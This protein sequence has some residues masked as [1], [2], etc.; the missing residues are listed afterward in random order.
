MPRSGSSRAGVGRRNRRSR[1][2]GPMGFG[3]AVVLVLAVLAAVETFGPIGMPAR[4]W[5]NSAALWAGGISTIVSLAL[6]AR[7]GAPEQRRAW[8]LLCAAQITVLLS[9]VWY[10][11]ARPAGFNRL[12]QLGDAGF[13]AGGALAIAG[14]AAFPAEAKRGLELLR[15]VLDGIVVAGSVVLTVAVLALPTVLASGANPFTRL[16]TISLLAVDTVMATVAGLL[17]IRGDRA[18]R[19]VLGMLSIGFLCWAATDLT[20][21]V[22]NVRGLSTFGTA[23]PLGWAAGYAAIAIAARLPA[24]RRRPT[25]SRQDHDSPVADTII[26]FGILLVAAAANAPSM[27]A[28]LSPWMGVLWLVLVAA[29]VFRQLILIAD[30]E[31]LRRILERRVASRTREL[32]SVTQQSELLLNS[33]GD[34]IYGVDPQGVITFVNP[35]AARTLGYRAA[36]LIGQDAHRW[37]HAGRAEDVAADRGPCYIAEAIGGRT[38]TSAEDTYRCADG[39]RIPV[40]LT[41]SPLDGDD[42]THGAVIVFRDITQRREVDRMKREFVSVVSHELRTPLT[43]IRGSL[44]LLAGDRLGELSPPANRMITIALDS[45]ERLGR[46]VNDILDIERMESGSMPMDFRDHDA[47]ALVRTAVTQLRPMAADAGLQ[48]ATGTLDGRVTA[49]ADRIVQTLVNLIGNAIKFSPAGGVV[50]V[51]AVDD[52]RTGDDH[53]EMVQFRVADQGRGI[54]VDKLERIFERFEQVDSS[55]GR[56][57]GGSGLGLAISRSIVERHGGRIWAESRPGGGA[58]LCFTVPR[59]HPEPG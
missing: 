15:M 57:M 4:L 30:N 55:D 44:G 20:R 14:M 29:V 39:R 18:D 23:L 13:F 5:I 11:I 10:A 2:A 40:E 51:S 34:G 12:A 37:F 45:T 36:D 17:V 38:T 49:D 50:T 22:F 56:E 26:T 31:R 46:L 8:R 21:W 16:D 1:W 59:A 47:A 53:A 33:V 9:D 6:T 25:A 24:R 27:P 3:A 43:A 32:A 41:A 42:T 28:A 35:S 7:G 54:P 19:P 58:L 52:H 48:L